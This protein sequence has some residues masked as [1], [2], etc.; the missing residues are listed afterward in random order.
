[1]KEY[2]AVRNRCAVNLLE[3][4]IPFDPIDIIQFLH[5]IEFKLLNVDIIALARE[6]I[7]KAEYRRGARPSESPDIFDCSS[8]VKWLYGQKGIWLPR[9]TIQQSVMGEEVD[10]SNLKAGD[11]I[12]TSGYINYYHTRPDNESI[13]HVGIATGENSVIHAANKRTGI[14]EVSLERFI[15]NDEYAQIVRRYVSKDTL[16]FETPTHR[17]VEWSDDFRWIILQNE[18]VILSEIMKREKSCAM[19]AWDSN[20][21]EA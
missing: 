3:L 11:L 9:R 12:F 14:Q 10:P 13:G 20:S 18:G 17:E 2:R 5:S 1:M 19:G 16:T 4:K 21:E 8:F 6:R 7:G 15:P